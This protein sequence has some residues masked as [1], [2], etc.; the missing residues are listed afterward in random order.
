M[1]K[2]SYNTQIFEDKSEEA[3]YISG[4]TSADGSL[5]KYCLEI[6]LHC[7]DL[8][9]LQKIRNCVCPEHPI[10]DYM[11]HGDCMMLQIGSKYIADAVRIIISDQIDNPT[12]IDFIRGFFDGDGTITTG[13][14]MH[15]NNY[16]AAFYNNSYKKL[17]AISRLLYKHGLNRNTPSYH[18]DNC[19][20]LWYC[21]S[22]SNDLYNVMYNNANIYGD[23]KKKRFEELLFSGRAEVLPVNAP[24]LLAEM[25]G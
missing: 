3:M 21:G 15:K 8:N 5:S 24:H 22:S 19:Y 11:K 12:S 1:R 6:K 7:R 18:G 2:Y 13:S 23:R 10:Y 16:R 9:I 14:K 25:K 4:L 20:A 17:E